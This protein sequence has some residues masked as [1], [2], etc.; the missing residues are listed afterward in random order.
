[1]ITESVLKVVVYIDFTVHI[2]SRLIFIYL[3]LKLARID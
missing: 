1:M 3:Y 2:Y